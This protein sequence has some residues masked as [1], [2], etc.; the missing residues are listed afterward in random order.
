MKSDVKKT[1]KKVYSKYCIK[2]KNPSNYLKTTT[3]KK[4][5]M[6]KFELHIK[7]TASMHQY[8]NGFDR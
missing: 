8:I 1:R 7:I 5:D 2:K 6:K 3:E 4:A